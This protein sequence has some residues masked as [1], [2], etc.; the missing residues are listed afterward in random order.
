MSKTF[1]QLKPVVTYFG[2]LLKNT[3]ELLKNTTGIL[4]WY[5][6]TD[7]Y[8]F[9]AADGV[10]AR[11]GYITINQDGSLTCTM[12]NGKIGQVLVITKD[13]SK[14]LT[15]GVYTISA[16]ITLHENAANGDRSAYL[17]IGR[18]GTSP[19][20][21]P[22]KTE[23]TGGENIG[24][25][26]KIG[27]VSAIFTITES[28]PFAFMVETKSSNVG[29]TNLPYVVDML[30]ITTGEII[31]DYSEEKSTAVDL[32]A[33]NTA[34]RVA[35]LVPSLQNFKGVHILC[36]DSKTPIFSNNNYTVTFP[37]TKLY[38]IGDAS[39]KSTYT[40]DDIH[41]EIP[42]Y[43]EVTSDGLVLNMPSVGVFGF[44]V[45]SKVFEVRTNYIPDASFAPLY[46]R[47]YG[48]A[49]GDIAEYYLLKNATTYDLAAMRSAIYNNNRM[50]Y[51]TSTAR[52]SFE[53][54]GNV[55]GLRFTVG[56]VLNMRFTTNK[57]RVL[58]WADISAD[59]S[60]NITINGTTATIELPRNSESLVYNLTDGLLHIRD[61]MT[62]D[63]NHADDILLLAIAYGYPIR[64][65]LFDE[66]INRAVLDM[67]EEQIGASTVLAQSFN[68]AFHTGATDFSVK[69]TEFSSLLLGDVRNNI[70]APSD[71]EA[72]LF[73]TDP[74]LLEFSG[75]ENRCYEF[76]SQIQKYY[77]STPTSFC[78]CGGDWLG[79]SDLPDTACFKMGY[80]D[81]FMHS[82]FDNC[83]MI[84]GNHDTNYQGKKDAESA[85]Y[86]TRLSNQSIVD[87]WYREQ[88]RAYYSFRGANTTF[89]CFD[90]G[91]EG[92][93]LTEYDNYGYE[94]AMWFANAL[95]TETAA[96]IAIAVH[97]V[98]SSYNESSPSSGVQP[99]TDQVLRIADAYNSRTTIT[100][101]STVYDYTNA[102]G[103][104][105]FMIGGHRHK[106]DN[107]I[108]YG[109]PWVISANVRNAEA[110][111]ATFDLVFADY[112][113]KKL[114][115]IR[116]G[117]GDNRM[118]SL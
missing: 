110:K 25:S 76:I 102:T 113:A 56:S 20:I 75:W 8:K 22:M 70:E 103:K 53:A 93:A 95:L 116:V 107:G 83:Y 84:V 18:V 7:E 6:P 45:T 88:K 106:D 86:T 118:I 99:L 73:F 100:V 23:R 109:I 29:N 112:G 15:P 2:E 40:Y 28:Q 32:I 98:H 57:Q 68:S 97:M 64:G 12:S 108:L 17:R 35:A 42:D 37:G 61:L 3:T 21:A 1:E 31:V 92:Q 58:S 44:N 39:D 78:L 59:I 41:T 85:T 80:I 46:Y 24:S 74:H 47:Y 62:G 104:V 49:F 87:L 54:Y 14:Q 9:T 72:F 38:V 19:V 90:T 65:Y 4:N 114:N 34:A 81:G 82:M 26:D 55:G 36:L 111:G 91:T 96:H 67:I 13:Q 115:L 10:S 117:N 30:Q 79:N 51:T 33:R 66:Y 89:Y 71:Y 16:R 5:D 77:N 101:N 43:T 27:W 94:Q 50:L 52:H 105:E 11:N 63:A 48:I 60:D 69:C